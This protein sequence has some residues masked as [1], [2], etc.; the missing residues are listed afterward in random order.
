MDYLEKVAFYEDDLIEKIALN[1]TKKRLAWD[2][3]GV[4]SKSQKKRYAKKGLG[5]ISSK[6]ETILDEAFTYPSSYDYPMNKGNA[7]MKKFLLNNRLNNKS[8]NYVPV[9]KKKK[10]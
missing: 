5:P 1:A 9:D 4:L 10:S 2:I 7:G 6:G 8:Q 3:P